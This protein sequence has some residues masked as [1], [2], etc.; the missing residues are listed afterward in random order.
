MLHNQAHLTWQ[1]I[2][3]GH[4]VT[5]RGQGVWCTLVASREPMKSFDVT[6]LNLGLF[7]CLLLFFS[8]LFSFFFCV[9]T[10]LPGNLLD[11]PNFAPAEGWEEQ[12]WQLIQPSDKEYTLEHSTTLGEPVKVCV[13]PNSNAYSDTH[14]SLSR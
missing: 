9:A 2:N 3:A 5:C 7:I 10:K 13:P 1:C 11:N 4:D 8:F 6:C 14:T 12:A